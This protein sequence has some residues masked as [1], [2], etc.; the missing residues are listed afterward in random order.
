MR[1]VDA[2]TRCR[3][4]WSQTQ[5]GKA[6]VLS[7]TRARAI[8]MVLPV[9][10]LDRQIVD[11]GVAQPVQAGVIVLPVLVAIRAEPVERVVVPLVSEAHRDPIAVEGPKF[12]D[13][14]VV[15]FARPFPCEE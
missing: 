11:A 13:Q 10:R 4:R 2:G 3:T 14:T 12:L 5:I 15:E 9:G 6:G 7:R 8:P 1:N